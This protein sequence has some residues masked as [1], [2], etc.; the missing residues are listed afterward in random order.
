MTTPLWDKE[1]DI[2]VVG[3]G[4]GGLLA[5]LAAA[6][7]QA[8]VLVVEKCAEFGGTSATSG[9]GIW[10]PNSHHAAA[11]GQQ[12]TP[13]EAFRYIRSL[14][15]SNVADANIHAYVDYAPRMLRWLEENTTIRYQS[16]PYPDYH[17]E[18]PGGKVGFRTHLPLEMDG[19]VLG[20]DVLALRACSP[21]ANL[22]GRI[23]WKFS[24]TYQLLYRSPGWQR[25]LLEML[26][27]YYLDIGQR[28]RS[29]KDR[30]L[31]LGT[32]LVGG[33]RLALRNKQV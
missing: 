3:S 13:E 12:D 25:T 11:A 33:L 7:R 2:L 18:L 20:D 19:R 16:L 17:A 28:L 32:A 27:R 1:V 29:R 22:F 30:F 24:E 21:A 31:S 10:I 6:S 26:G 4:A 8:E 14:S 9:G 23:N 15:A 5:A